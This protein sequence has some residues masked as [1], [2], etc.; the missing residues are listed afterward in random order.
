MFYNIHFVSDLYTVIQE[1]LCEANYYGGLIE[2][3]CKSCGAEVCREYERRVNTD[4]DLYSRPLA[5]RREAA[6]T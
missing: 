4:V 6:A 3:V 2:W 5:W 1:A